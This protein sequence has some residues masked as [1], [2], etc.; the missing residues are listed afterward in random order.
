MEK[1]KTKGEFIMNK[2]EA[3]RFTR[4]A[5][6][7]GTNIISRVLIL[8]KFICSKKEACLDI[9]T[10]RTLIFQKFLYDKKIKTVLV[11]LAFLSLFM[12][13]LFIG[14]EN[15]PMSTAATFI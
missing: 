10:S 2:K 11:V 7:S 13:K 3:C 6:A 9:Y 4:V 14:A 1:I 12:L 8:R 15:A 5:F